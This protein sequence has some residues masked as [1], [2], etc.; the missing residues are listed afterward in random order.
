MRKQWRGFAL[1]EV[2]IVVAILSILAALLFPVLS[3]A[4]LEA[5]STSSKAKLHNISL[6]LMIYRSDWGGTSDVGDLPDLGLPSTIQIART[7]NNL[8]VGVGGWVSGCAYHPQSAP[9]RHTMFYFP[10]EGGPRLVEASTTFQ[11][12]LLMVADD[13]CSSADI[14]IQDVY[15]SKRGLGVL[16]SG[17]L[18]DRV[19]PGNLNDPAWY[20]SH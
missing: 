8:G 6:A 17:T 2:L 12:D 11:E 5:K 19:A 16:L 13:Q 9:P 15:R 10:G 1:I 20:V 4:R 18:V 7:A 3:A 14:N